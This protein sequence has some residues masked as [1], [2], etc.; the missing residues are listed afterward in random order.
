MIKEYNIMVMNILIHLSLYIHVYIFTM[1][2]LPACMIEVSG[3]MSICMLAM[4]HII[5]SQLSI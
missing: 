5:T 2:I 3:L 1:C 4:F